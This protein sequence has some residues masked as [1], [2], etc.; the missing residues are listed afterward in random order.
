VDKLTDQIR[1]RYGLEGKVAVVTGS[2]RGIGRAIAE[3]LAALGA[4]VVVSSRNGEA[5]EAV[6]DGIR[7]AGGEARATTCH[8]GRK[9]DLRHLVDDTVSHFGRLDIL[10]CNAAVNPFYGPMA[11]VSDDVY[12]RIMDSNVKSSFWLANMAA[13]V[14]AEG[15]GGSILLISS[16][17]GQQGSATLGVYGLSKAAD[18][19]L[20]R[21]LAVE[22]GDRGITANCIAPGLIRTDFSRAIWENEGIRNRA[23]ARTPVKRLGE[24]RDV[25]GLA[26]LLAGPAGAFI[27]GQLLV[28]DGGLTVM[29]PG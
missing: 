10:V 1:T 7:E 11:D 26:C 12:E 9:A 24:P 21:N 15:G 14:M 22:W 23:E 29:E 2:S 3:E 8:I 19:A 27:T 13:P 4:R 25:A 28:V 20:A 6:A 5:C 16:I 17:G 18:A